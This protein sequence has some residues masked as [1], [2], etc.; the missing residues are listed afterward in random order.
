MGVRQSRNKED[1][2]AP[3]PQSAPVTDLFAK[4][5]SLAP[6]AYEKLWKV[7]LSRGRNENNELKSCCLFICMAGKLFLIQ[8][9]MAGLIRSRACKLSFGN[10][11]QLYHSSD[12]TKVLYSAAGTKQDKNKS[13]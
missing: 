8:P 4:L 11:H 10:C 9:I 3:R 6:D 7:S 2:S 12:I 5:G 13:C 1:L